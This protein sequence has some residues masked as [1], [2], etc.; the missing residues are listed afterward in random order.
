MENV[1][2]I[3]QF[4]HPQQ[5]QPH[6]RYQLGNIM[7]GD[8]MDISLSL[9]IH[10]TKPSWNHILQ[11]GNSR[12]DRVPLIALH[13]HTTQ[14]HTR[15]STDGNMIRH[16]DPWNIDPWNNGYDYDKNLTL[17]RLYN[18]HLLVTQEYFI[19]DIDNVTVIN[20]TI[21]SHKTQINRY[22]QIHAI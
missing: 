22:A 13:P 15:F 12:W 20:K 5:F 3:H 6:S 8:E 4:D 18:I 16:N 1:K 11:I 17:N 19:L 10:N 9:I 7:V 21:D 14:L 2:D